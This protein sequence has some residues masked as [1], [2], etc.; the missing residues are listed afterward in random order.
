M[1]RIVVKNGTL[2][3]SQASNY[4][5]IRK[6][7]LEKLAEQ[8]RVPAR[9]QGKSWRFSRDTLDRWLRVGIESEIALLQ[10][11]GTF[12]D[13]PDLMEILDNIYKSRGRTELEED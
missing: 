2:T 1:N 11:A 5:H 10:Q 7:V 9:R 6:P 13:D 3:L 12:K 4:L 8:G